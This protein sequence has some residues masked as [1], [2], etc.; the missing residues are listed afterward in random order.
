MSAGQSPHLMIFHPQLHHS[1]SKAVTD[2]AKSIG[3]P[4]VIS[5]PGHVHRYKSNIQ[6]SSIRIKL[7]NAS[8]KCQG[9]ADS[10]LR[11]G[12]SPKLC[13]FFPLQSQASLASPI[14]FCIAQSFLQ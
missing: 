10:V 14:S 3:I 4:S 9:Y 12:P 1:H 7:C 13:C 5:I 2:L 11:L 8:T 6:H